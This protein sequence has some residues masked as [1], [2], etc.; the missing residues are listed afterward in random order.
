M[1]YGLYLRQS[2]LR[3]A[4]RHGVMAVILVCVLVLPFMTCIMRDSMMYG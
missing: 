1:R 2:L 4:G 3:R